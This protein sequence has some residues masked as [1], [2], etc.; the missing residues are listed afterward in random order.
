[1]KPGLLNLRKESATPSSSPK[2]N[3]VIDPDGK[4]YY[5]RLSAYDDDRRI[6]KKIPSY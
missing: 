4:A 1:M 5:V 6:D 2:E 3:E